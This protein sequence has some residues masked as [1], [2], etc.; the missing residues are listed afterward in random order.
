MQIIFFS[1]FCKQSKTIN[2]CQF[3]PI[4]V[5]VTV[6][7]CISVGVASIG[8]HYGF[9]K[10]RQIKN[11]KF[12]LE[13]DQIRHNIVEKQ[14]IFK[15]VQFEIDG[16]IELLS[17][18]VALFQAQITRLNALGKRL[19]HEANMDK[20]EFNFD[21]VPAIGGPISDIEN[22]ANTLSQIHVV[23]DALILQLKDRE[24]QLTILES[25][26]INRD[27]HE[28]STPA[29][30]PIEKGWISSSYGKRTDPFNGKVVKHKGIDFAGKSGSDVYAVASGIITWEGKQ[31]GYGHMIEISHGNGYVTRYG[32]NKK[33]LVKVGERVNNGDVIAMLGSSGRSTGPHVHFE[34]LKNGHAINPYQFIKENK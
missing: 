9:E 28:E 4:A 29:G 32:H 16:Q 33:N 25:M 17:Q 15:S 26:Y 14:Q 22:E 1:Q 30:R 7:A 18:R 24:E 6:V 10:S 23:L 3:I 21:D 34:V 13:V 11:K 19:I 31:A 8:Y 27:L 2:L 5:M 20:G 12:S